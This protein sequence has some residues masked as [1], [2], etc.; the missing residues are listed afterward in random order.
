MPV[1][2]A[3]FIGDPI[4]MKTVPIT[5]GAALTKGSLQLVEDTYGWLFSD[6]ANG[7]EGNIVYACDKMTIGKDATQAISAGD[8]LYLNTTTEV[9]SPVNAGA[10]ILVGVALKDAAAAATTVLAAIDTKMAE[11]KTEILKIHMTDVSTAGSYFTTSHL[12]G[13]IIKIYTVLGG[14]II[15][16]DAALTFKI[17]GTLITG[18]AITITQAG[19]AAGDQDNSA[20]TALNVLALGDLVEAITDGASGNTVPVDIVFVVQTA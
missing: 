6:L 5:A 1:T 12:V 10:D 14:A 16:A 18:S 11:A 2:V 4:S 15:T 17:G 9:V 13:K 19:S 7:D 3:G 8:K 20:P